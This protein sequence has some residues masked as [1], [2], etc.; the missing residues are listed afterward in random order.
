MNQ[1]AFSQILRRYAEIEREVQLLIGSRCGAVCELCSSCCCR[2]DICEEA[3]ESP[4]LKKLHGQSADSTAFSDGYGWLT[5]HGCGLAIGR[6]PVCYEFFCDE[7]LA[8]QPDETHRYVLRLLGTLVSYI[9]RNALGHTHLVEITNEA[10]LDRLSF[11]HIK[12]KLNQAIAALEHIR[13]FHDNGFL[14][15]STLEQFRPILH[16]SAELNE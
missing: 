5:E 8:S 6:P 11:E 12:G 7:L 3:F 14:D 15:P 2:A 1:S 10:D 16:L 4:F 13:L 9:G